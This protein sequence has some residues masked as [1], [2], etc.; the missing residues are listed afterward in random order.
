MTHKPLPPDVQKIMEEKACDIYNVEQKTEQLET[1]ARILR[2]AF[3]QGFE[4]AFTLCESRAK[5]LVEALEFYA[6][7]ANYSAQGT[8]IG[9]K[10]RLALKN[11]NQGRE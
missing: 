10:A 7:E 6:D 9:A 5:E 3:E 8:N 4:H 11:W 1:H 2:S